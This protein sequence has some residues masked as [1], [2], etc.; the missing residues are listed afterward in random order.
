MT[1]TLL[2]ITLTFVFFTQGSFASVPTLAMTFDT[3]VVTHN[4]SSTQESKIQRAEQKIRDVIGSE[5]FKSRVLNHSYNGV[6][7]FVDNGGLTNSQIYTKILNAAETL[8][9]YKNNT[10]NMGVKLYY[11]KSNT[12]GFTSTAS[13]DI[14]INTKYFNSYNASQVSGNMM[15]EWLHKLG[16]HHAV[17]YSSSRNYSVPYAIGRIMEK[18]AAR[19]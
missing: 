11:E 7:K 4:M 5:E 17:N 9:P 6:K 18:L 13:K 3:D 16:F 15:H 2:S 10:M 12:V 1:K 14:N 8:R 19:Y